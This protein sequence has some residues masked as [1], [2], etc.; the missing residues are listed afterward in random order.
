MEQHHH[1]PIPYTVDGKPQT[2][3]EQ[4]LTAIQIL[5]RAGFSPESHYLILDGHDPDHGRSYREDPD[6]RIHLHAGMT[7]VTG[8]R[9]REREEKFKI[10]VN[11][12]QVEVPEERI[13]FEQ[14]VSLS[15]LTGGP[16]IIFKV[17]Y[18]RGPAENREGH[19]EPGQSV[20][21]KAGMIFHVTPTDRS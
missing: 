21:V 18:D 6:E 15:K 1:H 2:S 19:L 4:E 16:N 12:R 8:T 3:A 17:I 20:K 13:S 7:F 9:H 5:E 14:V 10:I 11:G